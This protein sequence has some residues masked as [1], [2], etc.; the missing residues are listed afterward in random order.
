[1]VREWEK[2]AIGERRNL[3]PSAHK[4]RECKGRRLCGDI[5]KSFVKGDTDLG[6]PHIFLVVMKSPEPMFWDFFFF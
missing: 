4:R 1:M 6:E 2:E 3:S 5:M